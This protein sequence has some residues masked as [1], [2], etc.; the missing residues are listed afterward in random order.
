[1]VDTSEISGNFLWRQRLLTRYGGDE[2]QVQGVL[3]TSGDSLKVLLLTPY[4][5]RALLL[6]QNGKTVRSEYFVS[7]H[8]PFPAQYILY[9]IPRVL[10]L[11]FAPD[12]PRDGRYS[13]T[14]KG[15]LLTDTYRE[16]AI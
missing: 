14:V 16:G 3:E 8:L 4:G 1:L 5:S 6:E 7:Q 12:A 2:W 11:G 10:F 9:D 15:E 13:H